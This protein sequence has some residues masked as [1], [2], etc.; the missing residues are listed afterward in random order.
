MALCAP[1]ALKLSPRTRR[2]DDGGD[3]RGGGEGLSLQPLFHYRRHRSTSP[4]SDDGSSSFFFSSFDAGAGGV[5]GLSLQQSRETPTVLFP[6]EAELLL[7]PWRG[8]E[9]A[10]AGEELPATALPLVAPAVLQQLL[11]PSPSSSF[12][13][14][15]AFLGSSSAADKLRLPLAV[16]AGGGGGG[17]ED[18]G[19]HWSRQ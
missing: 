5:G 7:G 18:D 4:S 16:V 11:A 13:A 1:I 6:G 14:A 3:S 9:E 8:E 12:D 15:S 19:S 2:G 17:G 10:A